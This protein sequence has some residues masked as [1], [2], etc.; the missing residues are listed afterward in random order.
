MMNLS[1]PA[2]FRR[3]AVCVS[4][5]ILASLL[6]AP[7]SAGTLLNGAEA[8]SLTFLLV[9]DSTG[10][11]LAARCRITDSEGDVYYPPGGSVLRYSWAGGFFYADS[12][13]S[14]NTQRVELTCRI[15]HGFEHE[16]LYTTVSIGSNDT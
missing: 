3:A 5:V 16:P 9:D 1:V 13:F 12:S 4:V 8:A 7:R 11:P 10:E 15:I 6:D 2:A 14:I